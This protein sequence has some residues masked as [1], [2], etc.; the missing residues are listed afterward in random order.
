[1]YHQHDY[2]GDVEAQWAGPSIRAHET[3]KPQVVYG[4][5]GANGAESNHNHASNLH[6]SSSW[7]PRGRAQSAHG[8]R[9]KARRGGAPAYSP[10][11]LVYD[12]R[13]L[14]EPVQE[15]VIYK[16]RGWKPSYEQKTLASSIGYGNT[17]KNYNGYVNRDTAFRDSLG[18]RRF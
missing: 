16:W 12:Q 14:D 7:S 10:D 3:P 18:R 6:R 17:H 1:M 9:P 5:W 13:V 2:H 11:G 4:A 15:H 8:Y